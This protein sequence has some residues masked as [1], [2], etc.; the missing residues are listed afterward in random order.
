MQNAFGQEI[1]IGSIVGLGIRSGNSSEQRVGVVLELFSK[2]SY[3][4]ETWSAKCAWYDASLQFIWDPKTETSSSVPRPGSVLI[5]NQ[6]FR[7]FLLDE[8]TIDPEILAALIAAYENHFLD[9][10]AS[11]FVAG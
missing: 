2:T 10:P 5:S 4:R 9:K 7:F 11:D 3:G 6:Q 8:E 1:T